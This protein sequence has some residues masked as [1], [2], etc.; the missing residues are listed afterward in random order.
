MTAP[1]NSSE[2]GGMLVPPLYY[3]ITLVM[4]TTPVNFVNH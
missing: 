1:D 4:Y 2:P 3:F